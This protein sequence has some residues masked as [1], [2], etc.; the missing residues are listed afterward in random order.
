MKKKNI[1]RWC[2]L[3]CSRR[4]GAV[5]CFLP[6]VSPPLKHLTT[7]QAPAW[8]H[9]VSATATL[10]R[11]L[12][13]FIFLPQWVR[14]EMFTPILLPVDNCASSHQLSVMQATCREL[15][16]RFTA[17]SVQLLF[18]PAVALK[19]WSKSLRVLITSDK[20]SLVQIVWWDKSLD[21][22]IG[23]RVPLGTIGLIHRRFNFSAWFLLINGVLILF[24]FVCLL[25]IMLL[26]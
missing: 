23:K 19:G 5:V 1:V 11:C 8:Q 12:F 10:F 15:H 25:N 24:L 7:F 4:S 2:V 26:F 18:L 14:R 6:L 3:F 16:P 20:F 21:V 13:Y 9:L 17:C 22:R